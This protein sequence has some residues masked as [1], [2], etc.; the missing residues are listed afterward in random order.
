M[1]SVK[2]VLLNVVD[3]SVRLTPVFRLRKDELCMLAIVNTV[4]EKADREIMHVVKIQNLLFHPDDI[5]YNYEFSQFTITHPDEIPTSDGR[6]CYPNDLKVG[7][8]IIRVT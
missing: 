8:C 2:Q 5:K 3:K 4:P 7:V 1:L 6:V